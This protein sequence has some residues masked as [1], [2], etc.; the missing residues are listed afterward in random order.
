VPR[1]VMSEGAFTHEGGEAFPREARITSS[2]EIRALFRRGKRRKTS[3]FDVFVSASPAAL[4]RVAF[5]V[6]K[7][8]RKTQPDGR[9]VRAAAVQRN[10][11]KRRLKEIARRELLP[12]LREA[13]VSVDVLIRARPEAYQAG[14][15][16]MREEL[17]ALE[18]WLCSRGS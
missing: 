18:E 10:R 13:A 1:A 5:V 15:P 4:S 12:T 9:S 3:H 2:D 7:P 11:L 17:V 6:P 8:K 16:A 14:F